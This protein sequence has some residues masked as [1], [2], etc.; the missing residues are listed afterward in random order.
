MY[1]TYSQRIS[2][3]NDAL[4]K[5]TYLLTFTCTLGVFAVGFSFAPWRPLTSRIP[6]IIPNILKATCSFAFSPKQGW[7]LYPHVVLTV[8]KTP[9]KTGLGKTPKTHMAEQNW[10]KLIF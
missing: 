10:A 1:G 3:H 9:V 8:V 2:E 5:F 6:N 7:Q 4:Y